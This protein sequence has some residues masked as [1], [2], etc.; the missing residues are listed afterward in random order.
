M[1]AP[2]DK[3]ANIEKA[4]ESGGRGF[5]AAAGEDGDAEYGEVDRGMKEATTRETT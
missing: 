2:H 1:T 4:R 5:P 3:A